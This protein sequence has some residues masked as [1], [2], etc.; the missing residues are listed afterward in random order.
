MSDN[1]PQKGPQLLGDTYKARIACEFKDYGFMGRMPTG[2][3]VVERERY[4]CTGSKGNRV[5]D[6]IEVWCRNGRWQK[7]L[8][9]DHVVAFKAR[10]VQRYYTENEHML[11]GCFRNYHA[12]VYILEGQFAGKSVSIRY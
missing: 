7:K 12:R 9:Y 2:Y 1:L 4:F 6:I 5:G 11:Y 8:R 3:R 10:I